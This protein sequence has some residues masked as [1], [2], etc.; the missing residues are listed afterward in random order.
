MLYVYSKDEADS[1]TAKQKEQ[2]RA[3]VAEIKREWKDGT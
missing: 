3:V 1:L 2:L